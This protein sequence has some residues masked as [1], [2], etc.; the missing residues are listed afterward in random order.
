MKPKN[1][2][3]LILGIDGYIGFA[4]ANH[5]LREGFE[6]AG[7]DNLSR[8]ERVS[9]LGSNSL[10]PI[11]SHD[12]RSYLLGMSKTF[13]GSYSICS[14]HD[15]YFYLT[16]LLE[17]VKPDTIVHLAEQ[18]SAPWSMLNNDHAVKTQHENVIGTLNLL[19]AMKEACPDAHLIKLGTMGE[20]GKPNCHIPEGVIP[21]I[22]CQHADIYPKSQCP[23]A[24]LQFP[25]DPNSFYHLSK[26]HDTH[27]ILF[28]CKTW[29]LT[30]T[31]IM[32][33]VVYGLTDTGPRITRFDYDEC[34]GT[35]INRFCAQAISDN[36]IT[37]YGSGYQ[38]YSFLPLK[39]SLQCITLIINNPPAKGTHDTINQFQ[40][41]Y[42]INKLAGKVSL[43]AY[44]AGL[45]PKIMH[46]PNPRTESENHIYYPEHSKLHTMGYKPTLNL[47]FELNNLIKTLLPYKDRVIKDVLMPDIKWRP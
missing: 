24:G 18:P 25:R 28:A 4:L 35:V 20:Y 41:V 21:K 16:K 23:M 8:R 1:K 17:Q 13:I 38:S 34:F 22:P 9:D 14:L 31:D 43:A 37:I 32:Q 30:A 45:K 27:N 10:T 19:W 47:Q 29:G 15:Y 6:V 33:G 12:R 46:I 40:G 39:D 26:V 5:L 3:I 11:E 7:L 42:D 2:R 44:I 36:P